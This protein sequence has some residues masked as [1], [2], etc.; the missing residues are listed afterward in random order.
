V[1]GP[2]YVREP[3]SAGLPTCSLGGGATDDH[4]VFEG[5]SRVAADA[6]LAGART[7][8]GGNNVFSVWHPLACRRWRRAWR[9][10]RGFAQWFCRT[11]RT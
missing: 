9:R 7:V 2:F 1:G 11:G 10:G 3:S 5:L 4:V 6:V 8:H